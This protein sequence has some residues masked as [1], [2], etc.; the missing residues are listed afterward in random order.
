MQREFSTGAV[1]N[2]PPSLKAAADADA[3]PGN[4]VPARVRAADPR[5]PAPQ[6]ALRRLASIR[7]EEGARREEV[8]A[9]AR[10]V[11][12]PPADIAIET[13]PLGELPA[14]RLH[15]VLHVV[16]DGRPALALVRDAVYLPPGTLEAGAFGLFRADGSAVPESLYLRGAGERP[17]SQP[18]GADLTGLS[19]P[20]VVEGTSY[21]IG[22]L[23]PHFGHF[24][25]EN[26]SRLWAL[27]EQDAAS[28]K[29]VYHY[30][31]ATDVWE[32]FAYVPAI[33]GALG[34]GRHQLVRIER[35]TRLEHVVV[36]EGAIQPRRK[37]YAG[38]IGPL[39]GTIAARLLADREVRA[40][41]APVYFSKSRLDG[42]V[43]KII[44][45]FEIE[46]VLERHGFRIVHPQEL[47]FAE[48]VRLVNTHDRLCG[49][50]SSALH[51]PL[52]SLEARR[53]VYLVAGRRLNASYANID[54]AMGH[55]STCV[56]APAVDA[57][58]EAF[59][60]SRRVARPTLVAEAML[61]ALGI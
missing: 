11:P 45:E 31:D 61:R 16:R 49:S 40:D 46:A 23:D 1:G 51:L 58:H 14:E 37:A 6:A 9:V 36:A 2:A 3:P 18:D 60:A 29:L 28:L 42:G 27:P 47:E 8:A 56:F 44:N 48:Q 33:L 59:R 52:M 15:G 12:G 35:P 5:D 41:S 26:A 39:Y 22:H 43:S 20:D 13:I 50:A 25:I 55:A 30:R 7:D 32:H 24:L 53:I 19:R 57:R 54:L 17:F 21:Y 38:E 34:I 10:S 4:D